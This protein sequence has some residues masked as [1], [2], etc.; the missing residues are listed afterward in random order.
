MIIT[1]IIRLKKMA[2]ED[3]RATLM[4]LVHSKAQ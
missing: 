4:T 1:M 2:Y 3:A